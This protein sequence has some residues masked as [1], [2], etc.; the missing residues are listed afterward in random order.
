MHHIAHSTFFTSPHCQCARTLH[1]IAASATSGASLQHCTM[2][3]QQCHRSW[4]QTQRP[5]AN[6]KPTTKPRAHARG[7]VLTAMKSSPSA[8]TPCTGYH[9]YQEWEL[10]PQEEFPQPVTVPDYMGIGYRT[11]NPTGESLDGMNN[12]IHRLF[13]KKRK[14]PRLASLAQTSRLLSK[15]FILHRAQCFTMN[16]TVGHHQ[17]GAAPQR[18]VAISERF[19]PLFN[20]FIYCVE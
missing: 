3:R 1:T 5:A 12:E 7:S 15:W 10:E 6:P 14:L 16:N 20:I 19:N 18:P 2:M 4:P 9:S 17:M 11:D 8:E 13:A